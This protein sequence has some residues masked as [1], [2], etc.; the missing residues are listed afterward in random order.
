MT[1][2][3]RINVL[4]PWFAEIRRQDGEIAELRAEI[5]RLRRTLQ[6]IAD[7]PGWLD[8]HCRAHAA[9]NYKVER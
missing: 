8:H 6:V 7:N 9:L 4:P 1:D 3:P 5:E 2:A